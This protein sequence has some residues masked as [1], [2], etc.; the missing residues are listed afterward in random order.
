M[1]PLRWLLIF[2]AVSLG[3]I[4]TVLLALWVLDG[5]QGF[6]LDTGATIATVIGILVTSALGVGLMGL[7]FY[8]D[9]SQADEEAYRMTAAGD[10]EPRVTDEAATQDG[11]R[12]P[13]EPQ[14]PTSPLA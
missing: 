8:S 14:R 3:S 9:R 7:V 12:D 5:F 2:A 11:R 6:G 13:S 4:L 10:E 1:T